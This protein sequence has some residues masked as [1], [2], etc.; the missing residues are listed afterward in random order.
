[1]MGRRGRD[2][3]PAAAGGAPA[4]TGARIGTR[5]MMRERLFT[6]GDDFFIENEHGQRAFW[7][8][9]KALRVRETLLFK[10][11]Q[12]HELYQIQEK[13]L[14][15]RDTL[16]VYRG[17]QVAAAVH[18]A[19]VSPLRDRLQID[20]PGKGDWTAQGNFLY[21]D[22]KVFAAGRKPVADISKKWFRVRD[23]YGVEVSPQEDAALVLALTVCI[24]ILC[25]D[26]GT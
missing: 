2:S 12:G 23:S 18:K 7:V 22:Y 19:F 4:T 15:V 20:V 9:G 8:D 6:F 17:N 13:M 1:M 24:D 10:D 21:H 26:T 16:N 14:R 25:H 11:L 3:A 5:F